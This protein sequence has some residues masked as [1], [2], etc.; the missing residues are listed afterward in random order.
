MRI[1]KHKGYT[2]QSIEYR[3]PRNMK[4][5]LLLMKDDTVKDAIVIDTGFGLEFR[6]E[7]TNFL[8]F[9]KDVK[10]WWYINK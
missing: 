8:C 6:K 9:E 3:K 5:V 10:G 7:S 1:I 4:V 2:F